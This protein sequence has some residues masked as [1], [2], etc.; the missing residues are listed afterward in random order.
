M[1][2]VEFL[3]FKEYSVT[4]YAADLGR[5]EGLER[6]QAL[7]KAEAEFNGM[8]PEGPDTEDHFLMML[9]DA[10][11][12]KEVGWTW[13]CYEEN[14]KGIKR[15]FLSDFL[16]FENERRKGYA[17]AALHEMEQ[18]AKTDGRTEIILYVWE[19]NVPGFS[20]YQK[21]GYTAI[22]QSESGTAMKKTVR[23]GF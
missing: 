12:G 20:L 13:F 15:V 1:T 18:K 5:G 11:T 16:I 10:E 22:K 23:Y 2:D 21:C 9:E 17:T 4:D 7:K 8:L 14:E 3:R 19:H 6:E